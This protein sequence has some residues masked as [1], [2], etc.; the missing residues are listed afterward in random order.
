VTARSADERRTAAD[1]RFRS[2]V[3]AWITRHA[4]RFPDRPALVLSDRTL[5]YSDLE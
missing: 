2:G 1:L 4:D 5:T 3:A